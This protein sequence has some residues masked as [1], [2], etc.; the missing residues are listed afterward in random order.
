LSPD[1]KTLAAGDESN[2]IRLWDVAAGKVTAKLVGE[3]VKGQTRGVGDAIHALAFTPDG[4]TLVSTGDYGDGTIRV[5]DVAE[6]KERRRI[7]SHFGDTKLLALS[8]DGKTVA[9]TGM[10]CVVRLW[11]LTTGKE[12][13][14]ELGS[15]GALYKVAVS[16][17]S[18]QVAAAGCDGVIRFWDRVTGKELRSFCAHERQIFGLAFSPDGMRLASSGSY[19]AARLWDLAEGKEIRSYPGSTQ[20]VVGVNDVCYSPDGKKLSLCSNKGVIELVDVPSGEIERTFGEGTIQRMALAADGKSLA[21]AGF[22]KILHVWDTATGKEKWSAAVEGAWTL[23]FAP[24]GRYLAAGH[25]NSALTL[26]DTATGK[27]VRNVAAHCGAVRAVAISPDCRLLA[28]S[29]D[30]DKVGLFEVESGQRV[31]EFAGHCGPVWSVAFAPDGR[32]LVSGSFDATALVWDLTGQ[33]SAKK[34]RDPLTAEELDAAWSAL[35]AA[36]A[37]DGY[38]AVLALAAAPKQSVPLLKAKLAEGELPAAQ[39]VARLLADLDDDR[40]EVREKASRELALLAKSVAGDLRRERE[41]TPSAEVRRRLDDLLEKLSGGAGA[42]KGDEVVRSQRIIAVLELA[43]TTEAKELLE[44]LSTKAASGEL[45]RHAKGAL[46][47]QA[48]HR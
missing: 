8:P 27:V 20:T 41:A 9:V 35:S 38:K 26:W 39:E 44:R 18:K 25:S 6:G 47:R 45:R 17:D 34:R 30:T 10:S 5:W 46:D 3:K 12:L 2:T 15:Q 14:S 4:K 23:G 33:K 42:D 21:G 29:G 13:D 22:D 16:A 7:K 40:F 48:K 1:G 31:E 19:E 32:S 36:A 43:A 11:D 28:A 24:D 37:E